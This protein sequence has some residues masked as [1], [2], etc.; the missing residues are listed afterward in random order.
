MSYLKSISR[1]ADA[2]PTDRNRAVDALRALSILVVVIGHWLMAAVFIDNGQLEPGHLLD[3][4]SWTHPLTWI[5]QVMPVFF[6]VGGFSN[7]VSWRS[8]RRRGE[9][10]GLWLRNR[11][12]R[13]ILPVVPLLAVWGLGAWIALR[14]GLAP[15]M[16]KL[17]SQVALVPTWF[18]ATYVLIVSLGP[19]TL[20]MWERFGWWSVAVPIAAAGLSDVLSIGLGWTWVSLLN[21]VFVWGAVHQLGYVWLDG[22]LGGSVARIGL[23]AVGLGITWALVRFGPYP[24]AMVGL[25]ASEVTNSSPP[26]LTLAALGVFQAGLILAFEQRLRAWLESRRVWQ[27]V[28]AVNAQIM[29]LYL[30]HLTAMV[31][32]IGISLLAGGFGLGFEP[33]S[34]TWWLSRPAWFGVAGLVTVI[35]VVAFGRFERPSVDTRPAP[36][37]WRPL[38]AVVAV[39]AGLGLLASGGIADADGLNGLTVA[40]PFA[41]IVIGGVGGARLGRNQD[42]E[43][44]DERVAHGT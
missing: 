14:S 10:Y 31:A 18:L 32:V 44:T 42:P 43:T 34:G 13:L 40:L 26:R 2:T 37:A 11:L 39:C 6:V 3:L 23:A 38:S 35:F 5:L 21:Y 1:I 15:E 30:W 17:A 8:A 16:L 9:M 41:G 28:V 4:A 25:D 19:V 29:T 27:A 24:V 22:K 20:L 12:R 36:P 7:G 33:L